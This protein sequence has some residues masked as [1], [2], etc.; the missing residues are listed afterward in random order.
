MALYAYARQ[1]LGLRPK[2]EAAVQGFLD[3][4]KS[5]QLGF[6][7]HTH[8]DRLRAFLLSGFQEYMALE[9]LNGKAPGGRSGARLDFEAAERW[10]LSEAAGDCASETTFHR[11][12]ARCVLTQSQKLLKEELAAEHDMD[13]AETIGAEISLLERRPFN[14]DL[15]PKLLL[16]PSEV[17]DLLRSARRRL[18]ELIYETIRETVSS[19][20]DVEVEFWDLFKSV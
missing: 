1:N 13:V 4:I 12:W 9:A 19:G 6:G 18:R 15:A 10:F 5:E 2:A 7:H 3:F 20:A 8:R 17:L 11:A 14:P 16:A